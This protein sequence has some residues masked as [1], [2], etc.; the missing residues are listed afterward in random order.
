[1]AEPTA[2]TDGEP[3]AK[4]AKPAAAKGA[5]GKASEPGFEMKKWSPVFKWR[6][7]IPAATQCHICRCDINGPCIEC[8]NNGNSECILAW[9]E[10]GH[11]FHNHC[12]EGWLKQRNTCPL[13]GNVWKVQTYNKVT[14]GAE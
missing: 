9:G 4:P 11:V 10:C 3:A 7:D 8:Q 6:W 12:M 1:M 13:D 14:G 2:M 5:R